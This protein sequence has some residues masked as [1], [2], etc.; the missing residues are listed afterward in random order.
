MFNSIK[1]MFSRLAVQIHMKRKIFFRLTAI[2]LISIYLVILAGSIVRTTG[3]GMGCPD[4][5]KCFGQWIPPTQKSQLPDNYIDIFLDKRLSKVDKYTGFLE[6]IGYTEIARKIKSDPNIYKEEAFDATKT[7]I[8]Y[9][10]RLVG[11][12][13]GNFMIL[14]CLLG[15]ILFKDDK[16]L[17]LF[18]FL[19]LIFTGVQ[20][21]FG[22]IVVASNLTPWTIT[23]H[24][25]FALLI[26]LLLVKLLAFEN[27]EM[28]IIEKP[29]RLLIFLSILISLIQIYM[30]TL[31][32][33]EI[34]VLFHDSMPRSE[35]IESLSFIFK[36]HRSFAIVVLALNGYI[37]YKLWN[38]YNKGAI[39]LMSILSLEILSGIIMSYFSVP[40]FAQPIHLLFS[41][42]LFGHLCY[43]LFRTSVNTES[44]LYQTQ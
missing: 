4:W 19:T 15:L 6:K 24:M 3:S 30:G 17:L 26:I 13:A 34:D 1:N 36:I 14:M 38:V 35:W 16:R 21:W 42:I 20:G 12:M 37:S 8:E 18:S 10:N 43:I 41:T 44:K 2:T 22:S 40:H 11:F 28:L 5:P 32:R 29:I 7:W 27:Q 25:F 33:Q 31:V 39:F 23:F 9:I